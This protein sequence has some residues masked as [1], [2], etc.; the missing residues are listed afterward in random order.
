MTSPSPVCTG[1]ARFA[2]VT[3]YVQPA[4]GFTEAKDSGWS[5]GNCTRNPVVD[6]VSLSVGTR[7]VI[8]V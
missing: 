4:L 3:V 1:V 7:K 5:A 8:T 6:A 2:F